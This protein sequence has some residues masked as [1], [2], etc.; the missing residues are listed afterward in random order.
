MFRL[1]NIIEQWATIYKPTSHDPSAAAKPQDKAFFRIDRFELQN[2]FDRTFNLRQ[3]PCVLYCTNIEAR[4]ADGKPKAVDYA[5]GLYLCQKQRTVANYASDDEGAAL[6]KLDLN[7][8]TLDLLAY[9]FTLADAV[10]GRTLPADVPQAVRDI[11]AAVAADQQQREAMRCLRLE[12]TQWWSAPRY[13]NG[14][15]VMGV[16]LEGMDPRRLCVLSERYV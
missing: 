5:Y 12:Q 1:D 16:G 11:A 8:M 10:G 13:K 6:A 9:L 4:L 14:W 3:K 2:E 7:D 15:W